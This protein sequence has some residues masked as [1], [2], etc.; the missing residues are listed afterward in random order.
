M[1]CLERL[2]SAQ[3]RC[4]SGNAFVTLVIVNNKLIKKSKT[5]AY[6]EVHGSWLDKDYA[7]VFPGVFSLHV[8]SFIT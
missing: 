7:A 8:G 1:F 3:N 5:I 6:N 2:H 4:G